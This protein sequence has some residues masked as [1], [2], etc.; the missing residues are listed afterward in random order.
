MKTWSRIATIATILIL[1]FSAFGISA[2]EEFVAPEETTGVIVQNAISASFTANEDGTY[3]LTMNDVSEFGQWMLALPG[4]I[5]TSLYNTTE[6]ELDWA[7]ADRI[8]EGTLHA[9][10]LSIGGVLSQPVY[11][12]ETNGFSYTFELDTDALVGIE[13]GKEGLEIPALIDDVSL[14]IILDADFVSGII[15]AR[16]SRIASARNFGRPTCLV[17]CRGGR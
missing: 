12:P 17:N 6:M 1:A 13:E 14:F 5:T 10:D 11:D 4:D 8:A 7:T 3:T 16:E 15:S 9:A 2:Q